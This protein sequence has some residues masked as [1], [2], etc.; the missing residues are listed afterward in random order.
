MSYYLGN[1]EINKLYLGSNL[2][3]DN[4]T[5]EPSSGVFPNAK[6][7]GADWIFTSNYEVRI[8]TNLNDSGA[9]SLRNA[10]TTS[11]TYDGVIVVFNGLSGTIEVNTELTINVA[12]QLY[13]AGQTSENGIFLKS[14]ATMA[15]NVVMR[16]ES[17]YQIIRGLSIA[18]GEPN[19]GQGDGVLV[20]ANNIIFDR[21]T[22]LWSADENFDIISSSKVTVQNCIIAE[23]TSKTTGEHRYGALQY[24]SSEV[25]WYQN[26]FAHN[27]RRN[28]L[29]QAGGDK[30][31]LVRNLTYNAFADG[32]DLAA[33]DHGYTTDVYYNVI[34]NYRKDG[35]DSVGVGIYLANGTD[36]IKIY[37]EGNI[38]AERTSSGQDE[39]DA[40]SQTPQATQKVSKNA[41]P[42]ADETILTPAQ[43]EEL[44]VGTDGVN[45]T[46]GIVG[47]FNR[48]SDEIRIVK[49]VINTTG[50]LM[51]TLNPTYPIISSGTIITDTNN[52]G[53]PDSL[54]G[55]WGSDT[56]GYVN[57]LA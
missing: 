36:Q 18:S 40:F 3:Y 46:G 21:C 38:N 5:P 32:G 49:D 9:G 12:H 20:I 39:Y 24:L 22:F 37:A 56:F 50:S 57:S 54:E 15:D 48:H 51:A 29:I 11:S 31:E 28:P 27:Y 47:T 33:S 41:Y 52:N 17:D 25:S 45:G 23:G 44:L 16:N 42:L 13:I 55:T 10:V 2:I 1:T 8:V 34:N 35:G 26:L 4:T 30:I 7:F 53:I 19:T 6:G 14:S 43:L